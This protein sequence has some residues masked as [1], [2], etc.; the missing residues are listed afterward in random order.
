M[1]IPD[2]SPA[3]KVTPEN[4]TPQT[5][6]KM[7]WVLW[8]T[9]LMLVASI[10]T[11]AL[12]RRPGSV[13]EEPPVAAQS[14]G[15]VKFLMEQQWLIRMKLALVEAKTVARQITST[16]RVVATPERQ[17][18][19]SPPVEGII[20]DSHPLPRIGQ[21]V[22][23]GQLLAILQQTPTAGDA[24]QISAANAQVR[25]EN[26]RLEAERRQL[27]QDVN[28][29]QARLTL[30]KNEYDR[31]QKLHR[32]GIVSL[33]EAQTAETELKAAEADFIAAQ[34]QLQ[35]LNNSSTIAPAEETTRVEIRSP[36]TGTIT[37]VHKSLGE[38]A[39]SGEA[40][41]EI[42]S[43][44]EVWVEAPLFEKD[45]HR[46]AIGKTA[47]F[48]TVAVPDVE[49]TGSLVNI[50]S[51]IDEHLRA[52]TVIFSVPNPRRELRIG[53]QAN[54]RLDAGDQV[55][56]TLIPREAVLDHE[57][58]KIVYVLLSGE[59]FERREVKV[60]DEYGPTIAILAGLKPGE[61]VVTQGAY[62]LKL[63]ELRPA[64][65]GAHT[66]ET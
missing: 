54:V 39:A 52:A 16:G 36:L 48:T 40:M 34:N 25:I 28:K 58:K 35:A 31:A 50:G 65:A 38:R 4:P 64:N 42:V 23:K 10:L 45:L 18:V 12:W 14:T 21:A 61:R 55:E 5:G 11:A 30:A 46:L 60:G 49:Y 9:V 62:Q 29:T 43:L 7:S 32:D 59:E 13:V 3:P 51:V 20:T 41:F 24:G 6:Q 44:D 66:H 17:A 27:A 53:M 2:L 1:G 8:L 22:S 56:A 63:Q 47:F 19:V 15:T 37:A 57:G 26:A 33:S